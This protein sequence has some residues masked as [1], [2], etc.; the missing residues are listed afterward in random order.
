MTALRQLCAGITV[1]ALIRHEQP[2][3]HHSISK[4]TLPI[5]KYMS[6]AGNEPSEIACTDA[7]ASLATSIS[8]CH[9]CLQNRAAS[10]II[11]LSQSPRKL[12]LL[13]AFG[14]MA[15]MSN[16]TK[17]RSSLVEAG[18]LSVLISNILAG[19]QILE[20]I[21][22]DCARILCR[23][24]FSE[25]LHEILVE[26][27]I[28]IAIVALSKHYGFAHSVVVDQ[29]MAH[30]LKSLSR[31]KKI[32]VPLGDDGG[33]EILVL[34]IR[35][36]LRKLSSSDDISSVIL[37]SVS[38]LALVSS[39]MLMVGTLLVSG[40]V[41]ALS[42][43]FPKLIANPQI[44]L[45]AS[46]ALASLSKSAAHREGLVDRGATS[47]L[48]ALAH[49]SQ[50]PIVKY[51]CAEALR[52]LSM[53]SVTRASM[54]SVGVERVLVDLCVNSNDSATAAHCSAALMNLSA[55][56][57][58]PKGIVQILLV[59][60][61]KAQDAAEF[62]ISTV[63]EHVDG[64]FDT[65]SIIQDL[66]FKLDDATTHA[67]GKNSTDCTSLHEYTFASPKTPGG[68]AYREIPPPSPT[69]NRLP[70][71]QPNQQMSSPCSTFGEENNPI[72]L[73]FQKFEA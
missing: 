46:Q 44:C 55:H 11:F 21:K 18:L 68:C 52:N 37:D 69:K 59:G 10:I 50:S 24:T 25:E 43:L 71:W 22:L 16:Q 51:H 9:W 72:V 1:C 41:E 27:R 32:H 64:N 15:C 13:S 53:E 62:D 57:M 35:R 5:I 30:S 60:K 14:A 54:I 65:A 63:E 20:D 47:A 12:S 6:T 26:K 40:V 73:E 2:E 17:L 58:Q 61:M 66:L 28:V 42:S 34:L 23:L 3:H 33:A 19:G 38:A 31:S 70:M 29:L 45:R 48:V 7:L 36:S 56:I 39:S 67:Q 4:E 49:E 8:G